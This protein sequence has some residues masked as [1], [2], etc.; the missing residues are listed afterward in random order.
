MPRTLESLA[1]GAKA[2]EGLEFPLDKGGQGLSLATALG[3]LFRILRIL[4][5]NQNT[6]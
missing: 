3:R 2:M 6:L 5:L 4:C 1:N